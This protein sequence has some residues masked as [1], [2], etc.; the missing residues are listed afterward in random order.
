MF[1][2]TCLRYQTYQVLPFQVEIDTRAYIDVRVP[3]IHQLSP[4]QGITTFVFHQIS[5]LVCLWRQIWKRC[6]VTLYE[7]KIEN[8]FQTSVRVWCC[9]L[10]GIPKSRTFCLACFDLS[11]FR[12]SAPMFRNLLHFR[13]SECVDVVYID[14]ILT[15]MIPTGFH[16]GRVSAFP[17]PYSFS[18]SSMVYK[19]SWMASS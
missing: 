5:F 3:S 2:E 19:V 11:K 9:T 12:K 18:V 17:V 8:I 14:I 10:G 13:E 4:G 6:L 7:P 1:W 16:E 15:S